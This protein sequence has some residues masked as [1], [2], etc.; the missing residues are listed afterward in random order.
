M[1]AIA[2]DSANADIPLGNPVPDPDIVDPFFVSRK[3][4]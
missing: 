3:S 4:Q 2:R 1:T